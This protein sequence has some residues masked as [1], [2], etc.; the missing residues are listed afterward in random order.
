MK[1]MPPYIQQTNRYSKLHDN[2]KF[3]FRPEIK[4]MKNARNFT[5]FEQK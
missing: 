2:F 3:Y 5:V 4:P 1:E